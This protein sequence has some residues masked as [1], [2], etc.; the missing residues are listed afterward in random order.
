MDKVIDVEKLFKAFDESSIETITNDLREDKTLMAMH[1]EVVKAG[2]DKD[3]S[4]RFL[5][6]SVLERYEGNMEKGLVLRKVAFD[7]LFSMIDLKL[8]AE[9]EAEKGEGER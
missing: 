6:C 1:K 8:R 3:E 4:R 2:V 5:I 7:L 9:Y